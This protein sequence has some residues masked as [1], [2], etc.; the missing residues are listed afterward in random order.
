KADIENLCEDVEAGA[1]RWHQ[2][3]QNRV[4]EI[5]SP[6]CKTMVSIFQKTAGSRAGIDFTT[7]IKCANEMKTFCKDRDVP[8]GDMRMMVCL[9]LNVKEEAEGFTK[10]CKSALAG[11][12]KNKAIVD[13]MNGT[14]KSKLDAVK[15]R[16]AQEACELQRQ[17]WRS[18]VLGHRLLCCGF[19]V[20]FCLLHHPEK[21]EQGHVHRGPGRGRV[22]TVMHTL[23]QLG[24]AGGTGTFSSS[25]L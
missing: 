22:G 8:P 13:K 12:L 7:R 4:Q 16:L 3:L 20:R 10:A 21:V 5:S 19:V 9:N 18:A 11:K 25:E 17:V 23:L 24:E 2:C 15:D 6:V 14:K 1:S